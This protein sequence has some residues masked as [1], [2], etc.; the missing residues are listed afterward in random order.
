M[1]DD[2]FVPGDTKIADVH[3]KNCFLADECVD[4]SVSFGISR[5]V[6]SSECCDTNLCNTKLTHGNLFLVFTDI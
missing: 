5:I 1:D 3:M 2:C 4:G 6:V